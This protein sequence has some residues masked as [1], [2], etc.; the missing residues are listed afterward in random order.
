M[1]EEKKEGVFLGAQPYTEGALAVSIHNDNAKE[2]ISGKIA[3]SGHSMPIRVIEGSQA[4]AVLA[5]AEAQHIM[6]K[7]GIPQ[8]VAGR[9]PVGDIFARGDRIQYSGPKGR[10]VV[11]IVRTNVGSVGKHEVVDS[12]GN[13]WLTREYN[14]SRR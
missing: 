8:K 5:A 9:H 2:I 10:K 4:D 1:A 13:K 6:N 12:Q 14:L 3:A 11:T 7:T